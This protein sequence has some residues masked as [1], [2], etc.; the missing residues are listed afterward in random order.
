MQGM[1]HYEYLMD[2]ECSLLKLEDLTGLKANVL[3]PCFAQGIQFDVSGR[4]VRFGGPYDNAPLVLH[5]N[6]NT[7]GK[8]NFYFEVSPPGGSDKKTN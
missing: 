2:F 3:C 6:R 5:C 4:L 7:K 1:D 8:S